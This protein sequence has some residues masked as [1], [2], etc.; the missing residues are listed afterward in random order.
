MGSRSTTGI[1]C[2]GISKR[3]LLRVCCPAAGWLAFASSSPYLTCMFTCNAPEPNAP[4]LPRSELGVPL[5]ESFETC[6]A[7]LLTYFLTHFGAFAQDY[8]VY[9]EIQ[10]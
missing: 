5:L 7:F 10:R 9:L 1:L 6:S 2:S 4:E 8:G 3:S